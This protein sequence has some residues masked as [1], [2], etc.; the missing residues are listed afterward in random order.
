[1]KIREIG[2]YS[3]GPAEPYWL[4]TF[5]DGA[6]ELLATVFEAPGHVSIL[7]PWLTKDNAPPFRGEIRVADLYEARLRKAIERWESTRPRPRA[8]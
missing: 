3:N 1:M 8:A 4:V 7:V 6:D 5:R 2:R